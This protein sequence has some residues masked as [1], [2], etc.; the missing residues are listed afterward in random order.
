MHWA[1]RTLD[2]DLLAYGECT[3]AEPGLTV[4]HPG[5]AGRNFVLLPLDEI[6]PGLWLP[7]LGPVAALARAV[8]GHGPLYPVP[9]RP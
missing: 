3:V 9:D 4:P 1:P 2:L 5:V 6:A 8:A 7:G